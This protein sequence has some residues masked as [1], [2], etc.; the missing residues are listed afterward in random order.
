[1]SISWARSALLTLVVSGLSGCLGADMLPSMP[2]I[3]K[4]FSFGS[5]KPVVV[6]AKAN[7]LIRPDCYTVDP[8]KPI[9]IAKPDPKAPAKSAAYLGQWGGGAW[10]GTVCHDLWVM[11]VGADGHVLMFD[12]H[13][14]GFRNDATGFL[15]R[16]EITPDGR[17]R[18]RKGGAMVTYW[19]EDG[20]LHGERVSGAHRDQIIMAKKS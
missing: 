1:M 18:V 16:G 5:A 2:D 17:I 11:E 15:R 4:A 19:I 20:M 8:Y 14:P 6:E 12:A 10:N 3:P 9:R 7:P 13:G